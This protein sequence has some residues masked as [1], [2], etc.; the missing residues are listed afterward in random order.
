MV[1]ALEWWHV[2]AV[3]GARGAR[4]M[5]VSE[6][7]AEGFAEFLLADCCE[8]VLVEHWRDGEQ[9]GARLMMAGFSQ[10]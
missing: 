8:S 10:N 9:I 6:A 7:L 1:D 4:L 5:F 3:Q 2:A